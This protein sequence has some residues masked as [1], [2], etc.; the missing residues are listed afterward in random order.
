MRFRHVLLAGGVVGLALGLASAGNVDRRE[1]SDGAD[2]VLRMFAEEFV[3][4]TPGTGK[5][6]ASFLMGSGKD[7]PAAEQPA[8]EVTFRAPFAIAR[9]EVTQELYEAL[10]GHNPSR[11][12]GPRNSVEKVSWHEADVFC[13][14]ATEALRRRNLLGPGEVIRL[15]SE[16][17]WEYACR[18][19]TAA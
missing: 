15:P 8:H 6:P 10:A 19:G 1:A 16:A 11:W 17:E 9:Y 13:H 5:F 18:A 14:K 3:Q 12:K 4:L 2:R 7:S